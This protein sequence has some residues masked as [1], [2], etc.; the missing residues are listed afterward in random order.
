MWQCSVI[1]ILECGVVCMARCDEVWCG[2][3]GLWCGLIACMVSFQLF[4]HKPTTPL[5]KPTTTPITLHPT[6][7]PH[8]TPH[9][10]T[11]HH[12]T[13][14]HTTPHQTT[15][16]YTTPYH[17]KPHH[18]TAHHTTPHHT[19]QH[20]TY[21]GCLMYLVPHI[22][23]PEVVQEIDDSFFKPP[24]S[25][26]PPHQLQ[27]PVN[28]VSKFSTSIHPSNQLFIHPLIYLFICLFTYPSIR[29]PHTYQLYAITHSFTC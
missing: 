11:P 2:F 9:H 28:M 25:S 18:I 13:P 1:I 10:T 26:L 22:S 21:I 12:T 14:H 6:P 4:S 5:Q 29:H 20:H 15:P 19:T 8:T 27:H 17:V 16:R 3:F 7:P 23:L 24:P